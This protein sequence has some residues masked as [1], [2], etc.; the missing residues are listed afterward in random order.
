[1]VISLAQV[2][3]AAPACNV[4]SKIPDAARTFAKTSDQNVWQ[5]YRSQ[6]VVPD[7]ALDSGMSARFWEEKNKTRSVY[8]VEPGEDTWTYTRYCFNKEGALESVNFE[9]RTSL[10]WGLRAEGSASNKGFD[11]NTVEFISLKNGKVIPKPAGVTKVPVELK[12]TVYLNVS[13][14]P[15]ASL[16]A[17][18]TKDAPK[19]KSAPKLSAMASAGPR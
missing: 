6:D 1:M 15:F 17:A 8:F 10:G 18:P 4:R 12:P 5:E 7:L 9:V 13:E 14:L 19:S 16:L 2:A 11:P 3:M